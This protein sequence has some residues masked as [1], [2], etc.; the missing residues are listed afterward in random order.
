MQDVFNLSVNQ[1]HTYYVLAGRTPLLV[2]NVN[3]SGLIP[4][5]GSDLAQMA[6]EYRM[7]KSVSPGENVAVFEYETGS[8][9]GYLTTKNTAGGQ[10]SEE[11]IDDYIKKAGIDPASVTRIYS[12]RVPC[13]QSPHYCAVVVGKYPKAQ[14][15]FSLSGTSRQNFM[16]L[17]F[18]RGS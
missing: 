2:H 16:D 10:H 18:M 9:P 12:E 7:K 15:S 8:G 17:L 4:L 5:G 6:K 13:S 3:C 14:I 11:A 1:L